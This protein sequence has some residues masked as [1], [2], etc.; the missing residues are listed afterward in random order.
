[1]KKILLGVGS[2]IILL[3]FSHGVTWLLNR[4]LQEKL[5]IQQKSINPDLYKDIKTQR[6]EIESPQIES[7]K[8]YKWLNKRKG[9]VQIPIDR[10]YDYYLRSLSK[11]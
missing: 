2:L 8:Q 7:L 5:E 10:A 1:M 4:S 11:S 9:N 3:G 6:L